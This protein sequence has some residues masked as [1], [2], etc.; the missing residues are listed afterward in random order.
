MP[1]V[2]REQTGSPRRGR[3]DG[4]AWTGSPRRSGREIVPPTSLIGPGGTASV[5]IPATLLNITWRIVKLTFGG[6]NRLI[7][8]SNHGDYV[9]MKQ[10]WHAMGLTHLIGAAPGKMLAWVPGDKIELEASQAVEPRQ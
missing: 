8:E 2:V 10:P 9:L 7:Y 5:R 6:D 3:L 1:G 4:V